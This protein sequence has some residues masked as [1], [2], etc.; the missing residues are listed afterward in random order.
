MSNPTKSPEMCAQFASK[1]LDTLTVWAEANQRV[2]HE[3]V[4]LSV[5]ATKETGRLYAELQSSTVEA[6]RES[7]AYWLKRQT[8]GA[9]I[10][11]DPIGWWQRTFVDAI[12]GTQKAFR[13]AET[14]AQA[15]TKGTEQL[16]ATAE[17]SGKEIQAALTGLATRMQEIY[18]TA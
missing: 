16:Q 2:M 15:L 3:L 12:E 1:A 13:L 4:T 11:T 7:Q 14:S 9:E 10:P 6:V 8:G 18:A 5:T 17:R